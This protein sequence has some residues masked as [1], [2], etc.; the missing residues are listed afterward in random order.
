MLNIFSCKNLV[1]L[2]LSER[3]L[4]YPFSW[5]KTRNGVAIYYALDF[6]ACKE[7]QILDCS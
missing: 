5:S 1:L 3:K 6:N 7:Y 4:C 2:L